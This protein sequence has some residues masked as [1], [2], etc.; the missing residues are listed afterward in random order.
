MLNPDYCSKHHP[1]PVEYFDGFSSVQQAIDLI[2][3][4]HVDESSLGLM[5]SGRFADNRTYWK[6]KDVQSK[7]K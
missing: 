4:K 2:P 3:P 1:N 7:V 5:G 6:N